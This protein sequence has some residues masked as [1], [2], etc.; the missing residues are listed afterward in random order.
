MAMVFKSFYTDGIA[1]LSYLVGDDAAG[2]AAIVDP[3]RDVDIYVE[4]AAA[5][6]LRL[7]YAVET[8]IHADFASGS[9][10]LAA[11][12]GAEIVG[13]DGDYGFPLRRLRNGEEL[14]LGELTLHAIHTPGHTPEHVTLA[15]SARKQGKAPFGAFTGDTLFNLDVGRPDLLGNDL[16]RRLAGELYDS[17]FEKVL[18]MGNGTAVWPGHGAGSACG[19]SLG[20][21]LASTVGHERAVNPALEP[22]GREAFTSWLLEGMPEPPRHYARLK[23]INAAGAP[24]RGVVPVPPPMKPDAFE[25]A[26]REGAVAIDTRSMLAF[27]GGHV[28]GALNI[29]IG[30]EFPTWLGWMVEH[31]TPIVLVAEGPEQAL[32]AATHAFRLGYDTVLG[33]LGQGLT[34]WQ[35]AAKPLRHVDQWTVQ[36][37][38]DRRANPGLQILDVRSPEEFEAGHVPGAQNIYVPHLSERSGELD[39]DRPVV[40]YCGTGYRASIGASVLAAA[41]FGQVFNTPGSWTAWKHAELPVE[42]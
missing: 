38:D 32:E 4:E 25:K 28:P 20:D 24:V 18:P 26:M 21:L 23:R 29:G 6:G 3:R 34:A 5:R 19:K 30:K 33:W 40:T 39:P 10:E 15:L 31:G 8:H 12:T 14:R 16:E 9:H 22:R 41:G 7:A 13:G 36:A 35:N 2:V 42:R 11:R 1:Q 27:G 37:L 17:L